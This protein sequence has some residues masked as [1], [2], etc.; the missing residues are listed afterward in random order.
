V[1][2]KENDQVM[3]ETSHAVDWSLG[4]MHCTDSPHNPGEPLMVVDVSAV[5][6]M[7]SLI[8]Q[9][10]VTGHELN[11]AL[12]ALAWRLLTARLPGGCVQEET[13]GDDCPHECPVCAEAW[14]EFDAIATESFTHK[15]R[16]SD[17]DRHPYAAGKNTLHRSICPKVTRFV[18]RAEPVGAPWSLAGL[19]A[20]AHH[21]MLNNAWASGM[22]VMTAE[23]AVEWVRQPATPREG[24]GYKLCCQ[25]LPTVPGT[26]TNGNGASGEGYWRAENTVTWG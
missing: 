2:L 16:L 25:C 19:P 7:I 6:E 10:H 5:K 14:P 15:V 1:L 23:E 4:G 21:G 13:I 20:F 9:G 22:Q 11:N 3:I 17:P 18:G 12:D 8:A 26:G 24:A